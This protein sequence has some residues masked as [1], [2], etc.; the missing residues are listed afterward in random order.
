MTRYERAFVI[1]LGCVCPC[2]C[3]CV[4]VCRAHSV[5]NHVS[6]IFCLFSAQFLD[7]VVTLKKAVFVSRIPR[8]PGKHQAA[9]EGFRSA[10]ELRPH[11]HSHF[12]CLGKVY[13]RW[14]G[15]ETEALEALTRSLEIEP[16][17]VASSLRAKALMAVEKRNQSES[18]LSFGE[19]SANGMS[20]KAGSNGTVVH[21]MKNQ[22]HLLDKGRDVT[23]AKDEGSGDDDG[24]RR[25]PPSACTSTTTISATITTNSHNTAVTNGTNGPEEKC[26]GSSSVPT[27][28]RGGTLPDPI[29]WDLVRSSPE[30]GWGAK[31]LSLSSIPVVA[32]K[33]KTRK[34]VRISSIHASLDTGVPAGTVARVVAKVSAAERS[35]SEKAKGEAEAAPAWG[36][37]GPEGSASPRNET[38]LGM[39]EV[40]ACFHSV[41]VAI[42][43]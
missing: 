30:Q 23:A 22:R 37:V 10:G 18:A 17:I 32:T 41:H 8:F 11:K 9:V 36:R 25:S 42:P 1:C 26:R 12:T 39:S 5:C 16:T 3:V 7:L 4:S 35:A 24:D 14:G 43:S 2:V 34:H 29:T 6:T 13:L 31:K 19:M 20:S 21:N 15:H 28:S 38:T 40:G 27:P 33:S